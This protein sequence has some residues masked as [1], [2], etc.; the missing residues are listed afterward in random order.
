M[1]CPTRWS[2]DAAQ[3]DLHN[4][5]DDSPSEGPTVAGCAGARIS[6]VIL[7]PLRHPGGDRLVYVLAPASGCSSQAL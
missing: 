6:S 2:S 5:I 7:N 4:A 1:S 3:L